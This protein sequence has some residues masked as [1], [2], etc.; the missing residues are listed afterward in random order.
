[1]VVQQGKNIIL[2]VCELASNGTKFSDEFAEFL[3]KNLDQT[4]VT[5]KSLRRS[6][7]IDGNTLE[8]AYKYTWSD[9][10]KWVTPSI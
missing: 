8:H 4:P 6:Y 7:M 10:T 1:M 5:A 3:K 2:N 9:F